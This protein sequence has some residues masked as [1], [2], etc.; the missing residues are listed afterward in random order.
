VVR[1]P[2]LVV[3]G[4][5]YHVYNRLARG[6]TL[7]DEGDE[8]ER[9]LGL[10]RAVRER[11]GLTL[12]AYCLMANHY[13]IA[14]RTGPVPLSRSIGFV[15]FRFGQDYNRRHRSSG[16]LW[17]SRYRAKAVEDEGYLQQLVAYIHLNPVTAEVVADPAQYRRSGHRDLLGRTASPLVDCDQ[18]LSLYGATL[19]AARRC[20]VRTLT[21]VETETWRTG[22]PGALP[23]WLPERDR[24]LE[25]PPP[26]AWVDER[27]LSTGRGRPR[28]AAAEYL[29]RCAVLL[30]IPVGRLAAAQRDTDTSR[31]RYL[32]AGVGIE[33][34]QQRPGELA[35]C[36]GRWPEAVGRWAQRAGQ[37][38]L[39]DEAFRFA[40]ESLDER[41]AAG[42]AE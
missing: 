38:R 17:Q 4:G 10:V 33:R 14:L 40:Y 35:R 11:D 18:T 3:E 16:P 21:R 41:L 1:K 24:P 13:H 19:R 25:P 5:V 26:S 8:G 7:F 6:A 29:D 39:S 42:F 12:F 30:G 9:F 20:Y 28:M 32:V 27:G 34:W 15:Q 37:L 31:L 2:R 36:L 23:W 22:L